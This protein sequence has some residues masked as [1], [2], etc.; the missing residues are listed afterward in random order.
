MAWAEYYRQ[1]VAFYGQ[2]L[3]QAQAHSQV[4]SQAEHCE[5]SQ[6]RPGP[7]SQDLR[8][9][10]PSHGGTARRAAAILGPSSPQREQVLAHAT[11]DSVGPPLR[12]DA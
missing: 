9:S 11:E 5:T 10:D 7:S 3:G 2:T 12:G 6:P 1:Q 4:R 8:A